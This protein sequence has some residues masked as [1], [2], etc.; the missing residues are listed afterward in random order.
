MNEMVQ[1]QKELGLKWAI[2]RKKHMLKIT[3]VFALIFSPITTPGT[4]IIICEHKHRNEN[5]QK[6]RIIKK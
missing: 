1:G 2:W 3:S 6:S 4:I 5:A